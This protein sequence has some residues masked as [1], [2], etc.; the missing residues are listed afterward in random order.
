MLQN[1]RIS[2]L[3]GSEKD[4]CLQRAR[5]EGSLFPPERDVWLEPLIASKVVTARCYVQHRTPGFCKQPKY[6]FPIGIIRGPA[7]R[8]TACVTGPHVSNGTCGEKCSWKGL[9]KLKPVFCFL[10]RNHQVS[11]PDIFAPPPG[12]CFP[13]SPST[14]PVHSRKPALASPLQLPQWLQH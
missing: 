8:S 11:S 2:L 10:S 13:S 4:V 14:P 7:P 3:T 1:Q 5:L 9:T 6:D 12:T